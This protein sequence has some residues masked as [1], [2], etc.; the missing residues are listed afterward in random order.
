MNKHPNTHNPIGRHLPG[1]KARALLARDAEVI[2]PSCP[3]EYP[4]VMSHGRGVE[5]WDVDD[6]RFLDFA[7]GIGVCSTG[8]SHPQ[9]VQAIKDAA[10]QFLHISSDFW[11][12]SIVCSLTQ[13]RGTTTIARKKST[14]RFNTSV[15]HGQC[16]KPERNRAIKALRS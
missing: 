10:D 4:F 2:S 11:H 14:I 1:P 7:A 16:F 12:G 8:H 5:V 13:L 15:R 6:N 3:R 9:V